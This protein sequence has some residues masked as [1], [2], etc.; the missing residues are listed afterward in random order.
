MPP[1]NRRRPTPPF[2]LIPLTESCP[3][4]AFTCGTR[5][6]AAEIN[7]YL[8]TR[9]MTEQSS[10]ISS[11]TVAINPVA[12]QDADVIIGFFTLS[13]LSIPL[14][15]A[16]LNAV[17]MAGAPYRSI[18]GYLLGRLGVAKRYQGNNYGAALIASAVKTARRAREETGGVFLAV[19]AKSD[20][21]TRWYK[22]L[23]F[24]F[25]QL[26]RGRSRLVMRL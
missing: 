5:P 3:V 22:K 15:S 11:V 16:V 9:A 26:D 21:L 6:G 8:H 17:G 20:V 12:V 24:G 19:D 18:G 25:V 1:P 4:G 13:P 7:E 14:S 2:R 23:E 10:G